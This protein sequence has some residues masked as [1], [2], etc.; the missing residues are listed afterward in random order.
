MAAVFRQRCEGRDVFLLTR[1]ESVRRRQLVD[2]GSVTGSYIGATGG[3]L[4]LLYWHDQEPVTRH[5]GVAVEANFEVHHVSQ[6][7]CGLVVRCHAI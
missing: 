4:G 5:T 1:E 3:S 6:Q 2:Q 7:V